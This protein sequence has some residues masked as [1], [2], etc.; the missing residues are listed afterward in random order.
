MSDVTMRK[1][2]MTGKVGDPSDI[3]RLEF[4]LDGATF[5]IDLD[6]EYAGNLRFA[7]RKFT[8]AARRTGGRARVR[9]RNADGTVRAPAPIGSAPSKRKREKIEEPTERAVLNLPTPLFT[10]DGQATGELTPAKAKRATQPGTDERK[11]KIAA[12]RTWAS[13][14]GYAVGKS[15]RFPSEVEAH[16]DQVGGKTAN[17]KPEGKYAATK[18]MSLRELAKVGNG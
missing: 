3:E 9:Q 10:D 17:V 11:A 7:L 2:D 15:A 14:V 6:P 16:Y 4:G 8:D 5:E 12:M 18:D 1:C 13:K